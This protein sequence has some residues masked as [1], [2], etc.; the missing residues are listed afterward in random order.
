MVDVEILD[1]CTLLQACEWIAFK[2]EPMDKVYE[3]Y[4]GRVRPD[5]PIFT[6][7]SGLDPKPSIKWDDYRDALI[8]AKAA[9]T[10]ALLQEK[11]KAI[12]KP[13]LTKET[14][15]GA[16]SFQAKLEVV[17]F[18]KS[19]SLSLKD[20]RIYDGDTIVFYDTFVDFSALTTIFPGRSR[21]QKNTYQSEYMTLM[22]EVVEEEHISE[23]NQSKHTVLKDIFIKK[24][25][26]HNL[27]AS[28]KL[29]DAM[30]TLI[31]QPWSQKGRNKKG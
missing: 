27:P 6:I 31:R 12:G 14:S 4:E 5:N 26:E 22:K 24:M 3:E 15:L 2:W 30:A 19:F 16:L 9:L 21:K 23:N 28:D 8:K 29:A 1:T 7:H 17:D 20:N 25:K 13:T 10:I 11:I 18:E